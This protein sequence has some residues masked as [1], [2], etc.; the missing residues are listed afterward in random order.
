M[1]KYSRNNRDDDIAR[2]H[3]RGPDPIAAAAG[4]G[5]IAH[6]QWAILGLLGGGFAT[7][8]F[9]KP[10]LNKVTQWRSYGAKLIE[11]DNGF[12][13]GLGKLINGVFG[14]GDAAIIPADKLHH[15]TE[16]HRHGFGRF[17]LNHTVGL[18]PGG[19]EFIEQHLKGDRM[20]IAVTGGG[21]FAFFGYVVLPW[22]LGGKGFE[23]GLEGKRQFDRAKDEIW[24]LR[25]ENDQLRQR[26]AQLK[27][28]MTEEQDLRV[29]KD[30][31][32]VRDDTTIAMDQGHGSQKD[33]PAPAAPA[34][35][36]PSSET[37]LRESPT[38]VSE[39]KIEPPAPA[40]PP[41][42]KPHSAKVD[43]PKADLEW[44]ESVQQKSDAQAETTLA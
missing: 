42:E 25:A 15:V 31:P 44:A 38:T 12:T 30:E 2:D 37:V 36:K 28:Q 39:P 35:E 40:A 21:L 29:S 32:V 1:E 27:T 10:V 4:E 17:L 41:I 34:A 20:T 24:D 26:N 7:W 3:Y 6:F 43:R 5:F 9:H 19:R 33:S 23:K 18:F 14:H 8:L 13:R 22:F 11:S 16:E